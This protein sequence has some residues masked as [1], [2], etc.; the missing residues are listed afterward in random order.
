LTISKRVPPLPQLNPIPQLP[1]AQRLGA[2]K[3]AATQPVTTVPGKQKTTYQ[4]TTETSQK[5]VIVE[6]KPAAKNSSKRS[7]VGTFL[8]KTGRVLKKPF[9]L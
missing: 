8:K 2:A 4:T 3:P 9:Q 6:V 1:P 5:S 7:R